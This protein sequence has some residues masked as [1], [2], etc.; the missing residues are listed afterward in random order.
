MAGQQP[1]HIAP[2]LPD[3]SLS[4]SRQPSGKP[5]PLFVAGIPAWRYSVKLTLAI[6]EICCYH[7]NMRSPTS[8]SDLGGLPDAALGE[9]LIEL[10]RSIDRMESE[11]SQC[12]GLFADRRG[13]AGDGA[14][15]LVQWLRWKC[16]LT[17]GGAS[18]R[19]E[20]A[21]NLHHLPRAAEAFAAGEIGYH[22]A[23]AIAWAIDEVGPEAAGKAETVLVESARRLDPARLRQVTRHLRHCVDPDG[24]L[25]DANAAY[26]RRAFYLSE[27]LDGVFHVD[28]I[29]D[30]EGG[31]ILRT[32]LNALMPRESGEQRPAPQRRADA[33]VELARQR[34][35]QGDLPDVG[36]QRP[37]LTITARVDTLKGEPESPAGEMEWASP[38]P[39]ETVR[40]LA[41]DASLSRVLFD[42]ASEPMD[43]GRA[44]RTISPALRR[45]LA[46]RDKG[47]R[48]P[49]CDRPQSWTDC[50]HLTHW[51]DGG[52]TNL[53]NVVS[54]C[55][56]HHHRVHEEGW[57]LARGDG[58]ALVAVQP[59]W[60][61][62][63][64]GHSPGL[65]PPLAS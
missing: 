50:H 23:A 8:I 30:A 32:A 35:D 60:T 27:S 7:T 44:T 22:H 31:A 16:R 36:G 1:W 13:F 46:A 59:S 61:A 39:A 57:R 43:V 62:L 19:V 4:S 58:G 3:R 15:S 48:F 65:A 64:S 28:G 11:F 18:E 47:C 9:K 54:L 12:L 5:V 40:R 56:R 33:L 55:R 51:A 34:L 45:A 10:R 42:P 29:L 53:A 14:V 6:L 2:C 17:P 20:V 49:G 24:A 38:V 25:R 26:E 52:E 21:R 37:H 63:H 41:C